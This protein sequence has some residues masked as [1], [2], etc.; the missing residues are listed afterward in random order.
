MKAIVV[1]K[2]GDEDAMRLTEVPDPKPGP[3]DVLIRV[4][5]TAVNRADLLQRR[6]FYPPPPGASEVI[7]LECAG[8]V[9]SV[10]SEVPPGLAPGDRVMALLPGGGY[11]EQVAVHHGSVMR[12]PA[13]LDLVAAGGFPEVYLTADSNV[14]GLAG[15]RRGETILVHG[16]GSGVGTATIQLAREAGLRCFVTAGSESKCRRCVEL[17]AE[18]AIDYNREDFAARVQELTGGRGVDVIFDSI[19]GSYF[20][21]NMASL[22][23]GGRLVIIG[24]TGGAQATI[25]LGALLTRRLSVIG[26]TL[27]ARPVEEKAAIVSAF[28]ARFGKA[29]E[30]GRLGV[31]VDRVLP[32]AEAPE[33]HRVV[34]RSEHFGKVVL[35]V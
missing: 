29:L 5:S 17:G 4:R 12:V 20:E 30:A 11:A 26:S 2:P 1:E 34:A 25:P 7:G 27:R 22:A 31:V 16:G 10:G 21:R 8:E 19:G 15:A 14:F 9:V 32:L 35:A 3:R 6:G 23:V 24:L 33:A 28:L 13:S 18:A